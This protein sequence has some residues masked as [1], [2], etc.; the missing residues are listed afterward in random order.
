VSRREQGAGSGTFRGAVGRRSP[1]RTALCSLLCLS[2]PLLSGSPRRLTAQT[3][4]TV[5]IDNR[6]VFDRDGD[7]PGFIARLANALHIRTRPSV[8]RNT[9]LVR[10]GDRYDS[11]R[12]AESERAL[13][14]LS[15]FRMVRV[16][17]T[18][19]AGRL[20]VQVVTADGWS[21][22]PEAAYSSAGGDE[23]WRIAIVEQN[24]FGTAT[25]LSLGF[26]RTPD[27]DVAGLF[28]LNPHFL[29]RKAALEFR[30]EDYSDGRRTEWRYGRPFYQT[31]AR[32]ALEVDGE[33]A[34]ERVLVFRAG[35]L[36]STTQRR[37][38]RLLLVGGFAPYAT[39]RDYVRLWFAA[40][41]RRED[42][43]PE[44]TSVFPR[45]ETAAVGAG[46]EIG[47]VRFK[48]LE[49]F[50][51][52]ARRED[53]DLSQIL[54]LGLWAAPRA[55]GY[56]GQVAGVGPE[57]RGQLTAVWHD[58]FA[59]LRAEGHG[60]YTAAGLDSGVVR[61][62][63]TLASRNL[64]RQTLIAYLEGGAMR[65][66]RPGREFD[67]WLEDRGPRLFGAHAFTGTRMVWG[68][69]ENRILVADDVWG[70]LGVGVAPFVDW[71]GAWYAGEPARL[72]GDAGVSLRLGPT[73]SVGG[74]SAEFAL[75]YRFGEGFV[76]RGWALAVRKGFVF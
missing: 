48:V 47:H 15:V 71:G 69:F 29:A 64:P 14:A 58:G 55:W 12:V 25:Q 3:V 2:W 41:W 44:S 65:R 35:L 18:R 40:Q 20:A 22:K 60:V 61:G 51:S 66:P 1:K 13:R 73:R 17:S 39:A 31:A 30:H 5:V 62:S 45:S 59:A 70:L 19:E 16:D 28:Y 63:L 11:A 4:D 46:M 76:G 7:G 72:G 57:V 68:A 32:Q 38:F 24:L 10:A 53:V 8:I 67:L 36:D 75:G 43:A 54:R 42:F 34:K 6:N 23:T 50:N 33:A 27:R 9:L 37:A 52:Y 21:T 56:P 74:E 49:H 26:Q